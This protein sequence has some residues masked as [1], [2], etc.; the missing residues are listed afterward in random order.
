MYKL[1]LNLPNLSQGAL[2]E[3]D[4]LGVFANGEEHLIENSDA[5]SFRQRNMHIES[6]YDENGNNVGDATV[7]GATLM[8]AFKN[9]LGIDVEVYHASESKAKEKP[10]TK[11]EKEELAKADD[12][13][14]GGES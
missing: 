6:V 10:L 14:E 1:T 12:K 9:T 2:V 3:L 8:T 4:G 7:L 5:D 11:K 13:N